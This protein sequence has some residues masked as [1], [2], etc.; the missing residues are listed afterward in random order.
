MSGDDVDDGTPK[1]F[2]KSVGQ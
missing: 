1:D 2:N